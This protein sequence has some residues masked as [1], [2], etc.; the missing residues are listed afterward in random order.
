MSWA[1]KSMACMVR[2]LVSYARMTMQNHIS[3]LLGEHKQWCNIR[4]A[5]IYQGPKP[6]ALVV[7]LHCTRDCQSTAA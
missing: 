1:S 5:S 6:A 3:P 7:G 2:H 4:H